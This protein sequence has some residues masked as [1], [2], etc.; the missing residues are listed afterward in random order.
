M[1]WFLGPVFGSKDKFYGLGVFFDTYD[2]HN[3]EHSVSSKVFNVYG[4]CKL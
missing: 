4:L 2:N 3:G 1:I